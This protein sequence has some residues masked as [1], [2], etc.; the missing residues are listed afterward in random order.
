[1][2]KFRFF[3]FGVLVF[4]GILVIDIF[5][6]PH[7]SAWLAS[8][9]S[10]S[11]ITWLNPQAPIVITK[12]ETIRSND[13]EDVLAAL[14]QS[15]S[16]VAAII[17]VDGNRTAVVASAVT[18]TADGVFVSSAPA[19]A[20]L[21]PN[22]LRL[23]TS[24]G[25]VA[26]VEQVLSDPATAMVFIK[27]KVNNLPVATLAN[28][29][30]ATTGSRAVWVTGT[31][32][33]AGP[34]VRAGFVAAGQGA[35]GGIVF[36]TD[37]PTRRLTIEPPAGIISGTALVNLSGEVLGMW[38]GTALVSSDIMRDALSRYLANAA[39]LVRP[40]FGF[41]YTMV[42]SVDARA[43][44]LR[45]GAHV[46]KTLAKSPAQAAGLLEGDSITEIDGT[47]LTDGQLLE[48]LLEKYKPGDRIKFL[49]YRGNQRL[50]LTL[51]VGVL[52]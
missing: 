21:I 15:K 40:S 52:K 36:N 8:I 11:G 4:L 51:V 47:S 20:G 13:N 14:D 12:R 38:D 16:K 37:R 30:E 2:K 25:S 48:P 1:M 7:I 34:L 10:L 19:L 35:V 46:E 27:A 41:S 5:V 31:N 3:G 17:R 22:Q 45:E 6:A 24:D 32:S 9:P 42:T 44:S 50:E 23:V 33:P 49:V 28:A 18:L 29:Q 43:V 26:L 39:I